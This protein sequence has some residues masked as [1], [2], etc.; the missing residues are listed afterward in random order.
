MGFF[1]YQFSRQADL[2]SDLIAFGGAGDF[3]HVDIVLS[4]GRLLGARSDEVGGAGQGVQI[5][6]PD[7]AK[8]THQVL[9]DVPCMGA[10]ADA[11]LAFAM[12]QL[13]KPYDKLAIAAF[14]VGRDWREDDAWFCSELGARSGEVGGF[15]GQMYSPVNKIT[16]VELSIVA[17]A[18]P[19]RVITVVK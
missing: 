14:V 2:T 13:G 4:D 9:I 18:V 6:T 11:A 15:F 5:R 1:R 16:P 12:A 8:W 3:S 10:E 17:S 7:Y 19:G